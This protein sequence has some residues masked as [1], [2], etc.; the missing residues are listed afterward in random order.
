MSKAK[1]RY[2]LVQISVVGRNGACIRPSSTIYHICRE[3]WPP[4]QFD[5][6]IDQ[7]QLTANFE[8]LHAFGVLIQEASLIANSF[9]AIIFIEI[10]MENTRQ[11]TSHV[12]LDA[13]ISHK[14]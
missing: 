5:S 7:W 6:G 13:K 9:D 10:P 4:T 11:K 12:N 8:G 2:Q 1:T 3:Q 14:L